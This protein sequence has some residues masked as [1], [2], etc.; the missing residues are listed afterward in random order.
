[1]RSIY[2]LQLIRFVDKKKFLQSTQPSP[3]VCEPVYFNLLICQSRIKGGQ[4]GHFPQ[5]TRFNS[6]ILCLE[7]ETGFFLI[8]LFN[9]VYCVLVYIVN[10]LILFYYLIIILMTRNNLDTKQT[11]DNSQN[12]IKL[13]RHRVE[14]FR[15]VLLLHRDAKFLNPAQILSKYYSIKQIT[16]IFL[17]PFQD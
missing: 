8:I 13:Q 3:L 2:N 4:A 10:I 15:K 7:V 16:N 5:G 14:N 12:N 9:I 6:C 17:K 1:M 11:L